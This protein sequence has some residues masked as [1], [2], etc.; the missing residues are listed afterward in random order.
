MG[1]PA[2]TLSSV[3]PHPQCVTKPPTA[4]CSRM[5]T[6]GAHPRTT[7]HWLSGRPSASVLFCS[8]FLTS[9]GSVSA[10]LMIQRTGQGHDTSARPSCISCAG[11]MRPVLPKL[12]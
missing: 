7:K 9:S 5:A 8:H 11:G 12:T 2:A 4:A 3:E 10:P 1:T 6:C